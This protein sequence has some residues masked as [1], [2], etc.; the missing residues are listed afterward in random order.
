MK[1]TA[2]LLLVALVLGWTGCSSDSTVEVKNLRLEMKENPLGIN[3]VQPRFSWQI[4]SGKPD[5]KQTAYQIQVAASPEQLESGDGLLWDS[6]VVRSDES[7]LVPYA[8]KALESGRPYY[9]RVKLT[10][11]QG[12]TPWSDAGRWSMA[13]LD[14]SEWKATWI[15]EDSLS[16]PGEEIGV[17]SGNNKTRL[18]ARYL[19]KEFTAD[20][21]VAR[22]VLYISGLGSYEAY[23]N[24]KKVSED[25]FAPMPSLYYKRI[26]YNVYDVTALMA[27][28]KNTLGVIL[29][30]GRFFSMRNP[31]MK[32]FGLPRLLAQLQIEYTDGSQETVASDTSW[33]I[34]SKGPIIANN[35]FDGEEYDAR[36][37]MEGWNTNGFNDGAWKTPDVME[38]PTG[39]LTAQQNP[40]IRVQETLKPVAIFE[41]PDGKYILDMGQNMVGWLSV[42][43]K[44]KKEIGRAHV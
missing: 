19:R 40:N 23:L 9:W 3:V 11:N 7:V 29:G 21:A 43:L 17:A 8:G 37:E 38:A 32:T 39:K 16:N 28:D 41:R 4:A 1:K 30:N 22:A 18:A 34:T 15:G 42:D 35:E 31:G 10:T 6:G 24:G 14:G 27:P 13:L 25:V 44:G 20:K 5:L 26:Y 36:L 12:D 2:L 33:K